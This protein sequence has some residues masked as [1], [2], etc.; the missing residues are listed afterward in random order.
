LT[1]AHPQGVFI[2]RG[3]NSALR[4]V[5]L[6]IYRPFDIPQLVRKSP[7]MVAGYTAADNWLEDNRGI[8]RK[9]EKNPRNTWFD[10]DPKLQALGSPENAAKLTLFATPN[11]SGYDEVSAL[12][13]NDGD[14]AVGLIRRVLTEGLL[15]TSY[16]KSARAVGNAW[17]IK[18]NT[19]YRLGGKVEAAWAADPDIVG[20]LDVNQTGKTAES[21]CCLALSQ[22]LVA[23]LFGLIKS[24]IATQEQER[25]WESFLTV[26]K[27]V[28]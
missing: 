25:D 3:N 26:L 1:Q 14:T 11:F 27:Q 20:I 18:I 9:Q 12:A 15:A 13:E 28:L 19:P 22:V 16:P 6:G 4:T 8:L 23:S 24:K 17:N 21:N 10:S 2:F 7:K 5:M